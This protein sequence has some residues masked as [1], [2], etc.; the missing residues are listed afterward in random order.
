M[1]RILASNWVAVPV[2]IAAAL[3]LVF[4]Y[5]TGRTWEV[6]VGAG[7]LLV[8]VILVFMGRDGSKPDNRPLHHKSTR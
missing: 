5:M 7:I 2:L 8:A 1:L 6:V 4:L 3:S